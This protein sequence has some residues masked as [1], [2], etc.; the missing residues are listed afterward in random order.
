MVTQRKSSIPDL[1]SME[2]PAMYRIHI[3][4]SLDSSWSERLAGMT[5][6]TTGGRDTPETTVLEGRLLDQSALAGVLNTLHDLG[7]PLI[8]VDCLDS[9]HPQQK[10][11]IA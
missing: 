2:Y 9:S 11:G 4:G 10:G 5:I 6:T 3:R 7:L 8:S 1:P